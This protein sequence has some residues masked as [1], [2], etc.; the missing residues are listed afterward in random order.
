[1]SYSLEVNEVSVSDWAGLI[2]IGA[3]VCFCVATAIFRMAD[4]Y[5]DT[6]ATPPLPWLVSVAISGLV[7][8]LLVFAT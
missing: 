6:V 4:H 8:Y 1:M 7:A 3:I 5:R 2:V